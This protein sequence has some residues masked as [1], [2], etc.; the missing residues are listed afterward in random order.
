MKVIGGLHKKKPWFLGKTER[1]VG[2]QIA[3]LIKGDTFSTPKIFGSHVQFP[4]VH[5]YK[6]WAPDRQP[7]Q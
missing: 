3:K 5:G 1:V 7:K 2:P 4:G 6:I